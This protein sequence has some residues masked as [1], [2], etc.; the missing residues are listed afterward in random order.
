L[1][2]IW[3]TDLREREEMGKRGRR[4]KKIKRERGGEI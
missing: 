1:K 2:N 4:E 3:K